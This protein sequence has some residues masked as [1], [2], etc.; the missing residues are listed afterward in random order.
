[1]HNKIEDDL[2]RIVQWARENQAEA[3]CCRLLESH[4][5]NH[6]PIGF[7]R[8]IHFV[9]RKEDWFDD[10]IFDVGDVVVTLECQRA[11]YKLEEKIFFAWT[12]DGG[13]L[14]LYEGKTGWKLVSR[15]QSYFK[16]KLLGRQL[17]LSGRDERIA[18]D[19]FR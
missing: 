9:S 19:Q 12:M 14:P 4:L 6:C 15:R 3:S 10:G 13:G 18:M 5:L 16:T 7:T 11:G 1:M 8:T 2:L 17:L